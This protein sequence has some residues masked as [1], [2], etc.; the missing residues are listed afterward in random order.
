MGSNAK[1]LKAAL[2]DAQEKSAAPAQPP[3]KKK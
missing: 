3:A 2:A 1:A